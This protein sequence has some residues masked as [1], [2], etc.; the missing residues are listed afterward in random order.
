MRFLTR[1]Q[2]RAF[3]DRLGRRQDWQRFYEGGALRELIVHGDFKTAH[4]VFELGC[5]TGSFAAT[6][7]ENQL[8]QGASYT[9]V[10]LSATMATLSRQRLARFSART[11][12]S[13]TD[14]SLH[15]DVEDESFDRF[16][17][18]YML[19]L[20]PPQDIV[21]ALEEAHR[22]L[23]AG[24]RLCLISLAHG[25]TWASRLVIK[26]WTGLHN[27]KPSLVGGCRPVELT[28]FLNEN[29][30]RVDYHKTVTALTIPSE[31]VVASKRD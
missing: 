15:F 14:G 6:L 7:L 13:Q 4:R 22:L 26:A 17:C 23:Q 25:E 30:W 3:Y 1:E 24:G 5:G 12:V 28:N 20:L 29:Q 31:V 10:D 8:P 2:A 27:L 18:N 19:D 11:Q 9:G 21:E 16:V